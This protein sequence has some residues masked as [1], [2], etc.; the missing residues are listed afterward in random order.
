MNAITQAFD[1]AI[2][3]NRYPV[4]PLAVVADKLIMKQKTFKEGW[5]AKLSYRTAQALKAQGVLV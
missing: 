2:L 3:D 5:S 1:L 4:T